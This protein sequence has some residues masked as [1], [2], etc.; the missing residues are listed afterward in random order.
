M[1]TGFLHLLREHDWGVHIV[2]PR[3]RHEK[4]RRHERQSPIGPQT[5]RETAP[6][7]VLRP[8]HEPRTQRV[9]LDVAA[10]AHQDI[11][12]VDRM[13]LESTLIY[14]TL[15]DCPAAVTPSDAM[16]NGYPVQEFRQLEGTVRTQDQMPVIRENAVRKQ[17][18]RMTCQALSQDRQKRAIVIR[19]REDVRLADAAIVYMEEGC[20]ER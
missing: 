17:A 15:S 19:S 7:P 2:N 11:K 1:G 9:A 8:A 5:F 6:R 13:A 3:I 16:G 4:R 20:G 14:G 12:R 10:G 18:D